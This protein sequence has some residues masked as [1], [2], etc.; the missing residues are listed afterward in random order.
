MDACS[1]GTIFCC[2]SA[3]LFILCVAVF[4]I[5]WDVPRLCLPSTAEMELPKCPHLQPEGI[6]CMRKPVDEV[7][8]LVNAG[9]CF[10]VMMVVE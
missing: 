5:R 1:S 3:L 9:I 6:C 10:A 8:T 4:G 7:G 2:D